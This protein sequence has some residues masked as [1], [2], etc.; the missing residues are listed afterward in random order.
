MRNPFCCRSCQP[1]CCS[2][3]KPM[4]SFCLPTWQYLGMTLD[5]DGY[6]YANI[7]YLQHVPF[8]KTWGA[9]PS[10]LCNSFHVELDDRIPEK[11]ENNAHFWVVHALGKLLLVCRE[12]HGL[13][14]NNIHSPSR[15]PWQLLLFGTLPSLLL[16]LLP[17]GRICSLSSTQ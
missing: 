14:T 12:V 17:A 5:C 6:M 4:P 16:R 7:E 8:A 2:K 9:S 3:K 10:V 13:Y 15:L 1:L 11:F